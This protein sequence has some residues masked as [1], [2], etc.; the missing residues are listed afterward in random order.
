[1]KEKPGETILEEEFLVKEMLLGLINPEMEIL[2]HLLQVCCK[3]S[4]HFQK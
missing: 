4:Q 3:G 1:M 2:P